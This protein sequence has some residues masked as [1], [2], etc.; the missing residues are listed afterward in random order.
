MKDSIQTIRFGRPLI[1]AFHGL[2]RGFGFR[3]QRG[4][5]QFAAVLLAAHC[6]GP[7][8]DEVAAL[9]GCEKQL[10]KVIFDRMMEAGLWT[11]GEM[12]KKTTF[13]RWVDQPGTPNF[14]ADVEVAMGLATFQRAP[15]APLSTRG[16]EPS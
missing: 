4:D 13:D 9:A 14:R 3:K 12:D 11:G 8:L 10:V 15:V 2:V 1:R 5:Y 6:L 16:G 7:D